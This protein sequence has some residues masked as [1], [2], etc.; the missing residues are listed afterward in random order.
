M[1]RNRMTRSR[2]EK[3][4]GGVCGGMANYFQVD[5]VVVRLIV[6][7]LT[8]STGVALLAYLIFWRII[9][10][11]PLPTA[12]PGDTPDALPTDFSR[13]TDRDNQSSSSILLP[14]APPIQ[15]LAQRP[16]SH[17]RWYKT[18]KFLIVFGI[19]VGLDLIGL[20]TS[21]LLPLLMIIVVVVLLARRR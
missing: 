9:P 15:P 5:P 17:Q 11:E 10:L 13:E 4:I 19:L 7:L 14:A 2:S 12:L 18:G 16:S 1:E 20:K 3:L 21:A 6:V 8:L